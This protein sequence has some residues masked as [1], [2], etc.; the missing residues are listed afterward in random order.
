MKLSARQVADELGVSERTVR[1]WVH[2]G[3][4]GA[5]RRGRSFEISL[6]DA[7]RL[8]PEARQRRPA[9]GDELAELRGRYSEVVTRLERIEAEL[10]AERRR[11]GQLEAQLNGQAA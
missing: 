7:R 2:V 1:R 10:A 5:T 9:A 6:S 3:L 11:N 8:V 4:L